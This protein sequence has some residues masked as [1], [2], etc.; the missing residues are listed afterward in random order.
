LLNRTKTRVSIVTY[1]IGGICWIAS[2]FPTEFNFKLV[3]IIAYCLFFTVSYRI[4]FKYLKCPNC[5]K[6]TVPLQWSKNG[7]RACDECGKVFEYDK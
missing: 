5:R 1:C 3:L 2:F 4:R 7:T 6:F